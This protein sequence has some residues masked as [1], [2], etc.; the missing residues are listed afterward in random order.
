[1]DA[2][3][4]LKQ[5][6]E[7]RMIAPCQYGIRDIQRLEL[8][9]PSVLSTMRRVRREVDEAMSAAVDVQIEACEDGQERENL[10]EFR[11]KYPIGQ[12]K[13]IADK[14]FDGFQRGALYQ[15][16]QQE[17]H[18]MR[19]VHGIRDGSF[20]QNAI[21]L[22][23]YYVDVAND[24]LVRERRKVIAQPFAEV[25][26]TQPATLLPYLAIVEKYWG[27]QVFPNYHYPFLSFTHPYVL[28]TDEGRVAFHEGHM[29][30]I[31]YHDMM[32]GYQDARHF[33][34]ES[35]Y[36]GKMLPQQK[37]E[38]LGRGIE[39]AVQRLIGEH[40]GEAGAFQTLSARA[41]SL[42]AFHARFNRMMALREHDPVAIDTD[43]LYYAR[44]L[45]E[46]LLV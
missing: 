8:I 40:P 14:V 33:L 26:F 18:P 3:H 23:P 21:Q 30:T 45:V 7:R 37:A 20:F 4:L 12:C 35:R 25:D 15:R 29:S 22:G 32:R 34:F 10:R 19:V 36:A 27:Y 31:L 44:Q 28:I 17:G 43:I 39:A 46:D 11:E 2:H 42:Q 41:N 38:E 16:L 5:E 6:H 13:F 1:M 24:T 9:V